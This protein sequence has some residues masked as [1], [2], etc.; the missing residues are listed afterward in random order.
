MAY[1]GKNGCLV[2]GSEIVNLTSWTL[3]AEAQAEDATAMGDAWAIFL[4]GLTDFNGSAEGLSK[5]ALDTCALIGASEAA[6]EFTIAEGGP[7]LAGGMIITG[8]TETVSYDANGTISYTIEGNDADGLLYA[9]A[10]GDT[11]SGSSNAF[12][13]KKLSCIADAVTFDSP[14]E[15][16][17]SLACSTAESTA[18]HAT[19]TGRT[20][21]AGVKSA[22]ATL[23]TVSGGDYEIDPGTAITA[24]KFYR[25]GGTLTS[26]YYT[27][28]AICT[29]AEAGLDKDGVG[30]MT[31]TFTYT[32][33]VAIATA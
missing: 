17:V 30:I 13:G 28:A 25:E 21:L 11:P 19:N 31:Y 33:T 16:S 3:N 14:R 26:G 5:K 24:L 1:H 9:A 7:S 18:A 22:T 12:H 2:I 6:G 27:G 32:D 20:R 23:V 8:I 15:W 10:G 29:G 4:A